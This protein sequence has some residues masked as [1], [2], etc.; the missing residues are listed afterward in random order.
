MTLICPYAVRTRALP[1]QNVTTRCTFN[2][3][4]ALLNSLQI[5]LSFVS[6]EARSAYS[7]AYYG[8]QN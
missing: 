3:Y 8:K 1:K 6:A 4:C 2:S 7:D 5:F